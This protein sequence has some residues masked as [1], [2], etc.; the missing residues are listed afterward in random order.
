MNDVIKIEKPTIIKAA[1][2]P[3][4][5]I[6]EYIG[7]VNSKTTALSIARM[8]SPPGW[9]EP[10]QTPE[11]DEYTIVLKGSLRVATGDTEHR[12]DAGQAIIVPRG[13]TVR[14]STP[15]GAEYIAVCLPAFTPELVHRAE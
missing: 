3:P 13:T 6:E 9:S 8:Q 2:D 11:F 10:A 12:I 14:Y 15:E 5:K 4:K 1:G 7:Q